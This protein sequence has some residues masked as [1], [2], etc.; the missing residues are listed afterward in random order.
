MTF[1]IGRDPIERNSL[2]FSTVAVP[3]RIS[4][5][6]GRETHRASYRGAVRRMDKRTGK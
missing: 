6:A 1:S 3:V 2:T 4:G 5:Q